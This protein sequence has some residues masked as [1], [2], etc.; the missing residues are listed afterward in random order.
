LARGLPVVATRACGLHA[1][2]RLLEVDAGDVA[3]LIAALRLAV[4][5]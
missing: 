4:G 5:R 2:P 1:S 3:G